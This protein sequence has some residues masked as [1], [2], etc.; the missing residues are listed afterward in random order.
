MILFVPRNIGGYF[1]SPEV[2]IVFGPDKI[3][4]SLMPVPEATVH[5]YNGPVFRQDDIRLPRKP[6][7]VY[8]VSKSLREQIFSDQ[9][10]RFGV[11]VPDAGHIVA[12]LFRSKYICQNY[13][14]KLNQ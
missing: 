6:G 9:F 2:G 5:E 13:P 8:P 4:A 12:A 1:L 10:F 14:S 7:I 11:F 3:S